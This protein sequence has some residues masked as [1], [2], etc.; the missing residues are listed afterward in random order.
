[1]SEAISISI[2]NETKIKMIDFYD[3]AKIEINNPYIEF[4]AKT[5]D[6]RIT[7]YK[8]NKAVFQGIN[9]R[10]EAE[11]WQTLGWEYSEEHIGSDEVGTGDY[12]GPIVVTAVYLSKENI[13]KVTLMGVQ[14]SKNLTDEKIMEI[15]PK[16][17]T[18]IPYSL[19]IM[20]N[21]KYNEMQNQGFNMNNLKAQLHNHAINTLRMKIKKNVKAVIDQFC[22]PTTYYKYLGGLNDIADN[23]VFTTKAESK[24]P[25]VAVASMISRYRFLLRYEE[26]NK[27]YNT[28]F[29][30]G[31]GE[32]VDI[33]GK[34][35][36][37]KYGI[38][39][40][41]K[42]AKMN[43]ANTQKIIMDELL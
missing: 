8:S 28:T 19:L 9:A 36:I 11:I 13:K 18:F 35:F 42:I 10:S 6:V 22:L 43:F 25:S 12:F 20:D 26:M 21:E 3:Y 30:K 14:D 29:P 38:N 16:L 32:V 40:L 24:S 23:L 17:I 31:A 1:M 34:E 2:T 37:N 33:F 5:D 27:Q 39:E 4:A 41:K 15:V 7:I